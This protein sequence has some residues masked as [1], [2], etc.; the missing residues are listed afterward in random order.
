MAQ[1]GDAGEQHKILH[2]AGGGTH[3]TVV[4]VFTD[5]GLA[6][7]AINALYDAGFSV[8][9]VALVR[10]GTDASDT[11]PSQ[12]EAEQAAS[13][14]GKGIAI[15][16]V[17]GGLIGLAALAIP[18]IGPVITA[19][20]LASVLGGAA[21]GAAFGGWIG[22]MAK[23]NVPEDVAHEYAKQLSE[24]SCL[25]MVLAEH[26]NREDVAEHVLADAG[27]AD[28]K[29]YPYE[30][31]LD[32][33]PGAERVAPAPGSS[34][35]TLRQIHDHMRPGMDVVGSD[36]Q[37]VGTVKEIH[38]SDFLVNRD[39]KTDM[40]IPF[41]AVAEVVTTNQTVVLSIP[42]YEVPRMKQRTRPG[43]PEGSP[44]WTVPPLG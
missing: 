20:W 13:G 18:G 7:K 16:G 22:S 35:E 36:G 30:V 4:G 24:G 1:T 19:G 33:F 29:S 17:A 11:I 23:L 2:E 3:D 43:K 26:G 9:Q 42:A 25:V 37:Q 41:S 12:A 40:Y 15:G 10:K 5:P 32:N 39:L 21:T 38:D 27:A 34:P 8:E 31:R 28:V 44:D 14:A 6:D